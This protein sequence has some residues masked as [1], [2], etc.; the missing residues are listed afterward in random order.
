[1]YPRLY[2]ARGLLREDGVIFISIDD[3]EVAQLRLLMDEIFG[4]ENFVAEFSRLTKRAGKT[5]SLVSNNNDYIVFY[6][7]TSESKVN[8]YIHKDKEYKYSDEYENTRGKYKLSQT[9]D[10]HSIQYSP[11]LDYEIKF[12]RYSF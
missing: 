3:N 8:D 12:G 6:K 11:S 10:Y 5:S 2:I 9:L 7:K 4:E 1:M